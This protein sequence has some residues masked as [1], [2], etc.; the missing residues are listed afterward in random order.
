MKKFKSIVTNI[1]KIIRK[2]GKVLYG[3]IFVAIFIIA[4]LVALSTLKIPGN[5]K[6]L[7]VQSGSMEPKIKLRGLV[8]IKP[9]KDYQKGDVIT[10]SKPADPKTSVTHR[11]ID[12][13]TKN[14]KTFYITKGD[15][16]KTADTEERLKEN[17]L[18][19]VIFTVP[20]LGY[21]VSFAKTKEGLLILVIIPT[22]IIIYSEIL[23]IK[24]EL[25]LIITR[26]KKQKAK[27]KLLEKEAVEKPKNK[28]TKS[29]KE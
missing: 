21:L 3:F 23:N 29:K 20:Y 7:V 19:K 16:N 22:V 10:I 9:F 5:Y 17:V 24:K 2:T 25:A 14:K 28:K 1:A 11:I 15:A 18:G 27:M 26:L 6:V 8:I 4:G 12:I 13:K